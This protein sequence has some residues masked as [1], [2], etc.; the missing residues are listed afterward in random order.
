MTEQ[1]TLQTFARVMVMAWT[2]EDYKAQ[3]IEEPRAVLAAA[4]IETPEGSKVTVR[5]VNELGDT[6]SSDIGNSRQYMDSWFD[7]H[8][9]GE[10][11]FILT[12]AP[13]GYELGNMML[14]DEQL[15]AVAGGT[16]AAEG[17]CDY[18]CCP[19]TCCT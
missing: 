6:D 8:K 13:E 16:A 17:C 14:S 7:G 2:D 1:E 3:L 18:C 9:T 10:Y 5:E 15:D 4:G 11:E 12:Q 19:C